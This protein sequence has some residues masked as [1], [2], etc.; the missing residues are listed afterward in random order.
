VRIVSLT[1]TNFRQ[2]YGTQALEFTGGQSSRNTTLIYGANGAGKSTILNAFTWAL[3][4][5]FTPSF[6]NPDRLLSIRAMSEAT[7]G[8]DV[9]TS[10]LVVFEHN[11][12]EYQVTRTQSE[13]KTARNSSTIVQKAAVKLSVLTKDGRTLVRGNAQESIDQILPSDLYNFFFFDGERIE[14]LVNPQGRGD[15]AKAIKSLLDLEIL[16]RSI[17]HL[18]EAQRQLESDIQDG[19]ASQLTGLRADLARHREDLQQLSEKQLTEEANVAALRKEVVEVESRLRTLEHVKS[20][21]VQRDQLASQ[22][23]LIVKERVGAFETVRS[24][25]SESG[26]SLFLTESS[27]IV[28]NLVEEKRNKGQ[29][30]GDIKK[31]FLSDLL[32]AGRCICGTAIVP[33]DS[34]DLRLRELQKKAGRPKVEEAQISLSASCKHFEE[35][36]EPVLAS[37]DFQYR[38]IDQ[39]NAD[40]LRVDESLSE[41]SAKLLKNESEDI[42]ALEDNRASLLV[43]ERK[44]HESIGELRARS[45]A[46]AEFIKVKEKK[47]TEVETKDQK[48]AIARDRVAVAIEVREC[49]QKVLTIQTARVRQK[50]NDDVKDIFGRITFKGYSPQIDDDFSLKLMKID[51]ELEDPVAKSTG[52]SQL[53]SLSF[54]GTIAQQAFKDQQSSAEATNKPG[55]LLAT[56][57]GFYPIVMDSPFGT[58][59]IDYQGPIAEMLPSMAPQVVVLVSRQQASNVEKPLSSKVGKCYV[60]NFHT[61]KPGA[62]SSDFSALGQAARIITADPSQPEWAEIMLVTD[63]EG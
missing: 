20:F 60:L 12:D 5:R 17:R 16:E 49:L 9:S 6:E 11:G 23:K 1:L 51:G 61:D 54:V 18:A 35:M 29:L 56:R 45:R 57:G 55:N 25:I 39:F 38:R 44:A 33:G 40:L 32:E 41:I 28:L 43:K 8:D 19:P 3:Y 50:L 63:L 13:R 24:R 37:I 59:D 36:A 21:Q 30:P 4:G 2:F 47:L 53:L 27:A 10:V 48:V 15:I 34:H 14:K 22:R 7:V 52:E 62:T 58:L 26:F 42:V 46:V 31:Q